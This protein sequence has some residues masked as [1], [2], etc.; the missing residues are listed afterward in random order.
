MR[1]NLSDEAAFRKNDLEVAAQGSANAFAKPTN[2]IAKPA[3][4]I[5]KPVNVI[6]MSASAFAKYV[7]AFACLHLCLPKPRVSSPSLQLQL[8]AL[9]PQKTHASPE[10]YQWQPNNPKVFCIHLYTND[11]KKSEA[12][13]LRTNP[14]SK[15]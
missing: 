15:I 2:V 3:Y 12:L 5:I 6:A 13:R 1:E 8:R 11:Q 9:R 4:V 10:N 14:K 7:S